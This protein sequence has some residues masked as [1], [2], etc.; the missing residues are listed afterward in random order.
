MTLD[1]SA[2]ISH[3]QQLLLAALA[4]E[5]GAADRLLREI[6]PHLRAIVRRRVPETDADDVLARRHPSLE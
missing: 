4:G 1:R 5:R 2:Q 3:D 6:T